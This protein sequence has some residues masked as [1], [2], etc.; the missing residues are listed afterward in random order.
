ML[1]S[2][3]QRFDQDGQCRRC[4][5][6]IRSREPS[7]EVVGHRNQATIPAATAFNT[8]LSL[9]Q[10]SKIC[11]GPQARL[12]DLVGASQRVRRDLRK[13]GF[14]PDCRVQ[15]ADWQSFHMEGKAACRSNW[16]GAGAPRRCEN[17]NGERAERNVAILRDGVASIDGIAI[18]ITCRNR[19]EEQRLRANSW[20]SWINRSDKAFRAWGC[21]RWRACAFTAD[22]KL[23]AYIATRWLCDWDVQKGPRTCKALL[24][25]PWQHRKRISAR[26]N[27]QVPSWVLLDAHPLALRDERCV[28][29][30]RS[31]WRLLQD[32]E[33]ALRRDELRICWSSLP[34]SQGAVRWSYVSDF[35]FNV[36]CQEMSAHLAQHSF[37]QWTQRLTAR[38]SSPP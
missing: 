14:D 11:T 9:P 7:H 6:W 17:E 37:D 22:C 8:A 18:D 21:I 24:V 3:G 16:N 31:S 38:A 1:G 26:L 23:L 25:E 30:A 36:H 13:N 32:N 15:I 33:R 12:W 34:Q 20:A 35:L 29:S 27:P 19:V 4:R 2:V 10:F 5:L 28:R